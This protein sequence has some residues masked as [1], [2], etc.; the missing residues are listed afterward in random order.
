LQFSISSSLMELGPGEGQALL[1]SGK[2]AV[3]RFQR[4]D[5]GPRLAACV[6]SVEVRGV[7][8]VEEHRNHDPEEAADRRHDRDDLARSGAFAIAS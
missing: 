1:A 8:V 6:A 5:P 7:V 2:R 3:H 4:V